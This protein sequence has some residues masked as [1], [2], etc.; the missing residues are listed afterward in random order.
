MILAAVLGLSAAVA[1]E[2]VDQTVRGSRDVRD[3]LAV[4]PL[5]AV[6]DIRNSRTRRRQVWRFAAVSGC[7]VVAVWIVFTA[8]QMWL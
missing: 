2:G 7:A 3:L 1:A 8:V 6:P 5:V 4:S